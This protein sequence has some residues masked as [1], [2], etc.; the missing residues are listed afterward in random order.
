MEFQLTPKT[1]NSEIEK[2]C[3]YKEGPIFKSPFLLAV[4]GHNF[5][6]LPPTVLPET[7]FLE[8]NLYVRNGANWDTVLEV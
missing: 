7:L 2:N 5:F 6:L 1:V 4:F 8:I 3:P